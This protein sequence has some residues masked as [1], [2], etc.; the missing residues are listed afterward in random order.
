MSHWPQMNFK[1]SRDWA[2]FRVYYGSH[3]GS[4]CALRW[5]RTV[6]P[7]PVPTGK[8]PLALAGQG[9]RR[10][11]GPGPVPRMIHPGDSEAAAAIP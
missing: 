5:R 1:L 8:S 11:G 7:V 6:P 2:C 4:G 9:R 3:S 10:P